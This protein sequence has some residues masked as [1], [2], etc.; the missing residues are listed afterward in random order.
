MIVENKNMIENYA[1]NI[2]ISQTKFYEVCP[3]AQVI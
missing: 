2:I 3:Y 1:D